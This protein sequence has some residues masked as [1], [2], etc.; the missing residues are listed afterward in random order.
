MDTI[1]LASGSKR[2]QDYF[3]LLGL[4]FS[5]IATN[6]DESCEADLSPSAM[7]EE[8]AQR[9]VKKALEMFGERRP[10]W[11]CGADTV[12]SVGNTIMGKPE[13]EAD[14]ARMLHLLSGNEHQVTTSVALYRGKDAY[15]DCRTSVSILKAAKLS[16]KEIDWYV[17]TGEW[18]GAAGGLCIQG[19]GAIFIDNINGSYSGIVGLPLREFYCMLKDAGYFS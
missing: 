19:K 2:R 18:Q 9:K 4:T 6:I 8:L 17:S 13:N 1:I 7:T 15:M 16:E 12:V 10:A 11:I 3:K 14:A 5:A